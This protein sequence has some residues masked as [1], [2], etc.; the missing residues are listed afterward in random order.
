MEPAEITGDVA[1]GCLQP[2]VGG[3]SSRR[4]TL[5]STVS[6]IPR[7]CPLVCF[8]P[9]SGLRGLVKIPHLEN[10]DIKVHSLPVQRIIVRLTLGR[11]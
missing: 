6:A 9:T 5:H 7:A 4:N 11:E 3:H 10:K 8:M 2:R 1:G